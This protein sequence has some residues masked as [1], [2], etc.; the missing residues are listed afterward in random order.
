M[1]GAAQ[2]VREDFLDED[3][4]ISGQKFVLLSFVSPENVLQR[5]DQFFFQKFLTDYEVEYKVKNLEQF[6]GNTV[7]Q[8]NRKLDEC[9]DA[10]ERN[11]N[12]DAAK[13]IREQRVP[14][15]NIMDQYQTFIKKNKKEI[16]RT[17]IEE[18]YKDFL[19][20]HQEK[21]ESEFHEANQFQTTVRGLKVRGVYAN[22][23]EASV[24][25]KKLMRSDPIHNIL[26]GEVGKWLPWDPTPNG[27]KE[28][29]YAEEQLNQLM[30]NYKKN[31]E[32]VDDFYRQTGLKRPEKRV[33]GATDGSTDDKE[34]GGAG[35]G[36]GAQ[37]TISGPGSAGAGD[38]KGLFDTQG[39]LALQRKMEAANKK[40]D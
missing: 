6:L 22:T 18:A 31:Q 38:Y 28:Q 26:V 40:D 37:N 13:A 17:T 23:Q 36:S 21:L 5:K 19:F 27:I 12:P 4:E 20:R 15:D 25:A 11:G 34:Q 39:D 16:T 30:G 32:N 35:A 9:A 10:A 7:L 3:P 24:R 1:S 14:V 2:P 33:F 8:M 29:E